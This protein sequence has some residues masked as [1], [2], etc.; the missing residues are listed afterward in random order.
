MVAGA[1]KSPRGADASA[2]KPADRFQKTL[3]MVLLRSLS[4]PVHEASANRRI[5]MPG[6]GGSQPCAEAPWRP[7][8]RLPVPDGRFLQL[9]LRSP[10]TL[11]W[12]WPDN[13]PILE[14]I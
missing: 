10:S 11:T 9:F 7:L 3:F 14:K 12:P 13:G 4:A 1:L 6:A 2:R 5:S 8:A